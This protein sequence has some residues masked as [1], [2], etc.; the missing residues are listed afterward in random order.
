[1][2]IIRVDS[3]FDTTLHASLMAD[4]TLR[5]D[6]RPLFLPE[7]KWVCEVRPAVR[8]DR[9][10]KAISADFAPR[11]YSN[12]ALVNYLRHADPQESDIKGNLMD[13]ALVLG[14]WMPITDANN[15]GLD[16]DT[17]AVN[18]LIEEI[19]ADTT[20][21][22]GDIIILPVLV[23]TYI[24]HLNQKVKYSSPNLEFTIK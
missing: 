6:K 22:T 16:I 15:A 20:L 17:E 2:K 24:P 1:M 4:S 14:E 10:G 7:G 12:V 19:S 21:K 11:Y 18:T 23:D 9:L 3:P 8:I 5:P 13:D